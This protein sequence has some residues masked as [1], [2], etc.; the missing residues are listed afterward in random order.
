M[1]AALLAARIL[2]GADDRDPVN[3]N[4]DAEYHEERREDADVAGR[5]VPKPVAK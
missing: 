4:T 5:A 1:M 3:V 2:V